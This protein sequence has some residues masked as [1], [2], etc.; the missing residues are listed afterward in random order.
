MVLP[1]L[2][3]TCMLSVKC[4]ACQLIALYAIIV[5]YWSVLHD[6]IQYQT[7]SMVGMLVTIFLILALHVDFPFFF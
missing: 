5:Y 4:F 1:Y 7:Y 6:G 3:Y 2:A